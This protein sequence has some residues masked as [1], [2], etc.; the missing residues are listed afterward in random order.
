MAEAPQLPE[1]V[2]GGM[3]AMP[4][5]ARQLADVDKN[6]SGEVAKL[7]P[8]EAKNNAA[9]AQSQE[10]LSGIEKNL[11]ASRQKLENEP[12]PKL[13]NMN[14]KF[15]HKGMDDKQMTDALSTMF[16]FA[17]IGGAMT[18]T[19]MTSAIKA[20][21][22]AMEGLVKGDQEVFKREAA[23]FDKNLKLAVAKNTEAVNNYKMIFEKNKG[24]HQALMDELK[25]EASRMHDTHMQAAAARGD[26]KMAIQAY[27]AQR[28]SIVNAEKVREQF[29]QRER[30]EDRRHQEKMAHEARIAERANQALELQNHR[31]D[32]QERQGDRRLDLTADRNASYRQRIESAGQQGLK[33]KAADAFV[34]NSSNIEALGDV[35]KQIDENPD[36]FGFKTMM[37]G[38]VL[39]RMDPE[40]TPVRAGLANITSMTIK[41]RAGT[42][43]TASE[44]KNLAPFIPR[45]GDDTETVKT[46]I[47]GMIKEMERMNKHMTAGSGAKPA[48]APSGPAVGEKR[49]I[50]GTP[51]EWDGKGWKAA[52]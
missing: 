10:K 25:L 43:Q 35:L 15:Q 49:T 11:E 7:A 48:G 36:A 39:N 23:T 3:P 5:A 50:N 52:Q 38:I 42:A 44:M 31:L 41:D 20:F 19:P 2:L 45:D 30:H 51:A 4:S 40:G 16:V 6:I 46:K 33:G 9:A 37:P 12:M 8:L 29:E 24:N 27:Q 13:D 28:T 34:H 26:I 21:G 22:G 14:E 17:A 18:R 1:K 32:M 47:N